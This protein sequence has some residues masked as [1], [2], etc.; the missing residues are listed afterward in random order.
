MV[1]WVQIRPHHRH[2]P[3]RPPLRSSL[4]RLLG[5][6]LH[7]D[8]CY[9]RHHGPC[10]IRTYDRHEH[11]CTP[12]V[13]DRG[14]AIRKQQQQQQHVFFLLQNKMWWWLLELTAGSHSRR[15]KL[16]LHSTNQLSP[17]LNKQSKARSGPRPSFRVSSKDGL[18]GNFIACYQCI[19]ISYTV[20][21][22]SMSK[23]MY[24]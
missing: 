5:K 18:S 21:L 20:F 7:G 14:H 13:R 1:S 9:I 6:W 15:Y 2:R 24:K 22:L 23:S 8:L 10:S 3:R 12:R 4:K 16:E 19:R 11:V 17:N